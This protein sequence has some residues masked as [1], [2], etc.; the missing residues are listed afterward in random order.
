MAGVG[1]L[2]FG[3]RRMRYGRV[4]TWPTGGLDMADG[5]YGC[6]AA[7]LPGA[8]SAARTV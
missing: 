2:L 3:V 4:A 1:V 6:L 8:H 5:R 7:V